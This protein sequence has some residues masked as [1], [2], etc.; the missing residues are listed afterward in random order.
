MSDL[1][2]TDYRSATSASHDRIGLLDLLRTIAI[3]LVV[4]THYVG[5][6]LPGGS[7]GVSIFFCLS[8]FL[9]T[10]NLL[11]DRV[12]ISDFL[13]RRVFRIYPTYLTVCAMHFV[14][15]YIFDVGLFEKY[16]ASLSDLLFVI[17]MP[18]DWL[19]FGVGVLWTLQIELWFYLLAPFLIKTTTGNARI[20]LVLAL[21]LASLV[22]KE[23]SFTGSYK[24]PQYSIF[25]M[26]FWMDN[27]LY[28]T[29][30]SLLL[31][32]RPLKNNGQS[33]KKVQL[34]WLAISPIAIIFVIGVFGVGNGTFWPLESTL[35]SALTAVSI[36]TSIKYGL[37]DI[38]YPAFV[39]YGSLFA[40]VTYLAHPFPLDYWKYF[41]SYGVGKY[42]SFGICVLLLPFLVLFLHYSVEQPGMAL[43]KKIRQ[44]LRGS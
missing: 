43:G 3:S 32:T 11:L 35:V 36:Y 44:A 4:V 33:S 15:L 28:G 20:W 41:P 38:R 10:N 9:I 26:L 24:V 5:K 7:V 8:G 2:L 40:Y 13:V 31:N 12:T 18:T 37:F 30:I 29:L 25:N 34:K 17:K 21:I 14:L 19:G 1:G 42:Q 6:L 23:L 16:K 22:L 27:L 39:S